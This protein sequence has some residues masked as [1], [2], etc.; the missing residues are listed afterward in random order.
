MSSVANWKP[1]EFSVQ[2]NLRDGEFLNA[3]YALLAAGPPRLAQMGIPSGIGGEQDASSAKG[4][5]SVAMPIGLVQNFAISHNRA[6]SRVFEIGSKRSFWIP[7][8]GVGQATL[9]RVLY[10]G[11]S[12]L[13]VLYSWYQDE[14]PPHKIE[15]LFPFETKGLSSIVAH[16]VKI[17]AG[18]DDF[19]INLASD[20]FTQPLGL[21]VILQDNNEKGYASFYLEACQ[22]PNHTVATDSQGLILQ[23]SVVLQFERALPVKVSGSELTAAVIDG[24]TDVANLAA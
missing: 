20:L 11:W 8:R 1:L 13:R 23:E 10:H 19:F 2:R 12:L 21:L 15:Q 16:D 4:L 3:S 14:T 9:G 22:I 7:G 18:Y 17:P 24:L 6:Y 5:A